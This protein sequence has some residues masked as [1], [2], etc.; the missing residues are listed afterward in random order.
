MKKIMLL[1]AVAFIMGCGGNKD[2]NTE[3]DKKD[4]GAIK[5][6][7][8]K[9][10]D[11]YTKTFQK[12]LVDL[13]EG[14]WTL[15]THIV[16][17]DTMANYKAQQSDKAFADFTGS[18]ENIDAAKKFLKKQ[19]E[20]TDLQIR[21]FKYILFMAGNNPASAGNLVPKKIKATNDQ[22]EKLFGFKYTLKGKPVTVNDL[23]RIL[24]ESNNLDERLAAWNASKEVG[25]T[26][27][28]GLVNLQGLRN[29]VVKPL[30]YT[31]Y[32]SYQ[33]SE[34]EM[35]S[36]ELLAECDNMVKELWPLYRELHTWARYELADKYKK[37]VPDLLPAHWLPNRWGQD[38]TQL[39][40]VE[41]LD[42]DAELKKK[43]PE[44]IIQKAEEFYVGMGFDK[45]P[46]TFWE[47]SSLYPVKADAGYSK[48][49]HA[50]AW[51]ID[52]DKD[53]RSLMSVEPNSEWWGTTLH[54]MGHIFYYL[55]YSKPEIPL[56]LRNGTNR[57]Y[58]EA[59]G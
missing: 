9:F 42:I 36:E 57:G 58:H 24:K 41:G 38:W 13:N 54:E 26:L 31:D 1:T 16:P 30:G 29:G 14:Q 50:S 28:D 56:I 27:K 12:L 55:E 5:Q 10:L 46:Q 7:A 17:G 23:D 15:Q 37:P 44:W 45:L 35:S 52:N 53:V 22:T 48:N 6:E 20:L 32:F 11:S 33:V 43:K 34:Y 40:N 2:K 59:F 8:Q 49:N 21:Q 18:Q 4:S 25:K 39:V 3:G 47:K 51:H 19:G